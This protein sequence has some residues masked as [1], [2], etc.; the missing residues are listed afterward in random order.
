[1]TF[2]R[3]LWN[4][5]NTM[6][7]LAYGGLGHLFGRARGLTPSIGLHSG[8]IEFYGNPFGGVG[9]I[10]LGEVI[11]Y[12]LDPDMEFNGSTVRAHELAHV[13][14][15][16]VVGPLYL[17]LHLIGGLRAWLRGEAWSAPGNRNFM[18][19]GPYSRPPRPWP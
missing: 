17:P 2:W 3:R 12:N 5:P 14:Q 9:A 15:G 18:E 7:G 10:T 4:S 1:M 13:V 16:Q 11:V 19:V 6:L 8:A